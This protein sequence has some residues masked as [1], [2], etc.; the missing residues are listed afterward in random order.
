MKYYTTEGMPAYS[1]FRYWFF[2]QDRE[3]WTVY[4]IQKSEMLQL[5]TITDETEKAQ[6]NAI[7]SADFEKFK[8]RPEFFV[9]RPSIDL[10]ATGTTDR[11]EMYEKLILGIMLQRWE[12]EHLIED[13]DN[14]I[15]NAL[16][17]LEW[18][19]QTDFY[20]APA[21]TVYHESHEGGLLEHTMKVLDRGLDLMNCA[22]FSDVKMLSFEMCALTHDWCKIG[23][24]EKYSKNVK[25]DSTGKWEQVDAF[26]RNQKGIPL[27]H[28]VSSMFLAGK[29][30]RLSIDEALAIRHHMGRWYCA[31]AEVDELQMS[32][33]NYPLVHLLQFA[34]QLSIVK[35]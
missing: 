25:N 13:P 1:D 4:D 26:K 35:Y 18:L 11:V 17:C 27:G 16:K 23:L 14:F 5:D 20:L 21:S 34:D 6:I 28:G 22:S 32:N 30:F 33:E 15:P 9:G 24:Y 2:Y 8:L 29:F 31:D 7:I 12:L 10:A 3:N 19:R